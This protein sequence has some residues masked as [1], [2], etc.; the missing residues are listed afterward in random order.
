MRYH[1]RDFLLRLY[2]KEVG[3][4]GEGG[5]AEPVRGGVWGVR[6]WGME[7]IDGATAAIA[8]CL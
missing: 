2:G 3:K 6:I 4:A 1:F 5:G 8:S 7:G